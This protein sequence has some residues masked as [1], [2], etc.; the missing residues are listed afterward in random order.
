MTTAASETGAVSFMPVL[1]AIILIVVALYFAFT[2]IDGVG[3]P[4]QSGRAT[5][6]GKQ[7]RP[8]GQTYTRQIVGNQTLN[9]PQA[10][11]EM[12]VLDL[13]LDGQ[14]VQ[15]TTARALYE[16]LAAGDEVSVTYQQRRIT[17]ALQVL[18]VSR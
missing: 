10:T 12:F 4:M 15:G 17:G 16:Q 11:P 2:A 7:Y 6:L 14:R 5:V 8:A 13:D 18:S 1:G 3:L 9:V